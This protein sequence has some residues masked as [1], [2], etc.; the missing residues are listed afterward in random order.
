MRHQLEQLRGKAARAQLV[1]DEIIGRHADL[2]SMLLYPEKDLQER[3]IAG[4]FLLSKYPD[5]LTRLYAVLETDCVD[6][7]LIAFPA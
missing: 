1:C 3:V 2:L 4:A 7:Q 5:L 6:H